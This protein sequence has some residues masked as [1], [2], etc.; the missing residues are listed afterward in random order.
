MAKATEPIVISDVLQKHARGE[1]IG[2]KEAQAVVTAA[3]GVRNEFLN[4]IY[5]TMQD[6]SDLDAGAFKCM[7]GVAKYLYTQ[8]LISPKEMQTFMK[9]VG[10]HLVH[11]GLVSADELNKFMEDLGLEE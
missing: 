3:V 5:Q 11:H 9:G 6:P 2:L 8:G 7:V 10:A 1:K 4:D